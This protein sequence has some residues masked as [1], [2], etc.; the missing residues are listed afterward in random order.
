MSG[1]LN[2]LTERC[3]PA[4]NLSGR[5]TG[6]RGFVVLD[7]R[8]APEQCWPLLDMPGK[9]NFITLFAGTTLAPLNDASPWLFEIEPSSDA[10][11]YAEKLCQQRLG[12][13]CQPQTDQCLQSFA[14]HLRAL[15]VL[16]DSLGGKSLI[17]LQQ[18]A[19][20]TALLASAPVSVYSHWLSPLH[21]VATP[22]PQGQWLIWQADKPTSLAS[23]RWQLNPEMEAALHESQQAWWLSRMTKTP[24]AS[25]PNTWLA[26]MVAAMQAGISR[27]D[28]LKR[29]LPIITDEGGKLNVQ[30]NDILNT[31]LPSRQ[32]VQ[33]L[34]RLV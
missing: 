32:K 15:F 4:D 27:S 14:D 23:D 19:V 34:E 1:W 22:T 30:I 25:L 3:Y 28:H 8:R 6:Q 11:H 29:L 12:W 9:Y 24:L 2:Q 7:Q 16:N 33:Q 5:V 31:S 26:R 18:P 20:W 17:N 21:Q 13:V 10:W